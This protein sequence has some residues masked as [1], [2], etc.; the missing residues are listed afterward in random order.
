MIETLM[1]VRPILS[2]PSCDE[3]ALVQSLK[4]IGYEALASDS[5]ES[6][7]RTFKYQGLLRGGLGAECDRVMRC[8]IPCLH[9]YF[10]VEL[11]GEGP[12][13]SRWTQTKGEPTW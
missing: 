5:G 4:S 9:C 1:R 13:E 12:T 8:L 6:T 7:V 10:K 2:W 11:S 3:T